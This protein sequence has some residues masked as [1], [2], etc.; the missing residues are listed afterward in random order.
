MQMI[1]IC[2]EQ[3]L[4]P[5]DMTGSQITANDRKKLRLWLKDFKMEITGYRPFKEAIITQGG[6]NTKEIFPKTMES[7]FISGLYIA[8]ELLDVNGDT[9]GYNLQASFSTGWLAGHSAALSCL[10]T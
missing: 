2:L 1:E 10:T 8:G 7:K 5:D 3:T 6:V 9:G 4:I